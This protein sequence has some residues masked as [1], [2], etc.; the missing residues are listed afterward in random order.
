MVTLNPVVDT[1]LLSTTQ[2]GMRTAIGVG[3]GSGDVV[4]PSSA[5]DN[6]IVRYDGTTG[7]LVQDSTVTILDSGG[8]QMATTSQISFFNAGYFVRASTGLEVQSAD[9]IRFLSSGANERMRIT[10]TGNVGINHTSPSAK[11]HVDAPS[12]TAISLTYGAAAG[13]IFTNENSELAFGLSNASPYPLYIQGRSSTNGARNIVLQPLGGNVGIGTASP[14]AV[15]NLDHPTDTRLLFNGGSTGAS[16]GIDWGFTSSV[17]KYASVNFDYDDRSS[18]GLQLNSGYTI[19]FN[20]IGTDGAIDAEWMRITSAGNVGINDSSP[21]HKLDVNGTGRFTSSVRFDGN[22]NNYA[23]AYDIRR[24][25]TG[26]VRHRIAD[27]SLLIGVTNTAGTLHY[28]IVLNAS[29]DLLVFNNEEGE[30]ARF[31]TVGDFGIN[32]TSPAEKLH[33]AG[34]TRF[35]YTHGQYSRL[36]LPAANNGASNGDGYMYLWMSEPGVTWTGGGIGRNMRNNSSAFTRINTALTSQMMR[37]EE[38]GNITFTVDTGSVRT[39]PFTIGSTGAAV[40][41]SLTVG[42]NPVILAGTADNDSSLG[43]EMSATS[44]RTKYR[45][46]T[47]TQYGIGMG[48]SYSFGSLNGYAM[49]FQM[50]N[51]SNRG[52]WWGDTAHSNAQGAM[53]LTTSGNLAVARGF[54]LGYGESDTTTASEGLQVYRA[55]NAGAGSTTPS[56]RTEGS[57]GGGI[58]LLDNRESGLYA[59]GAGDY[60]HFYVGR[61]IGSVAPNSKVAMTATSTGRLGIGL[62]NPSYRLQL[63]S[64]SAAK[65]STSTWTIT[66]DARVK[67]ETGEYTKGLEAVLA[68]RPVTYRYNGKAGMIDDGE[69]KISIIAQEAITVFPECVGSYMTK[70]EEDDEEDTEVLNWNGHALTFALVNSIKEL[71]ARIE[72]IENN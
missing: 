15:L 5:T 8:I 31:N 56:I 62:T 32:V 29:S 16:Y 54:R 44:L 19:T 52:F 2:A 37:F 10:S 6:A 17:N 30:M 64:D 65:P 35:D 72:A 57:Y 36:G 13:Q 25:G 67:T 42:G 61:T 21:S 1:L 14:D 70:L 34:N 18:K 50:N 69:D 11:L 20:D 59:S 33:V 24:T 27:Q 22:T 40:T 47:D 68:L 71:V 41:G 49:S 38:N 53:S 28:P 23:G 39:T 7:K 12:T 45:M 26:Y 43:I 3:A 66:S 55:F 48:A 51:D 60:L 4:G 63:S 58:A 46:W 9:Y